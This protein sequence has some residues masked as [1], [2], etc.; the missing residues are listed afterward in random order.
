MKRI[1]V[2]LVFIIGFSSLAIAK[3]RTGTFLCKNTQAFE[4]YSNGQTDPMAL[5]SSQ[6]LFK[7]NKKSIKMTYDPN[8]YEMIDNFKGYFAKAKNHEFLPD[9]TDIFI[10]N[11]NSQDSDYDP[12]Y[13][14]WNSYGLQTFRNVRYGVAMVYLYECMNF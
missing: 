3:D 11:E 2:L 12:D 6:S 14:V 4:L 1:L 7:I 8:G 9:G 13:F 5:N 10:I